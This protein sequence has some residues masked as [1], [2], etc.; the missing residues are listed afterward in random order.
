MQKSKEKDKNAFFKIAN[1]PNP[2]H[3]QPTNSQTCSESFPKFIV[4]HATDNRKLSNA[5]PF[6]ISK[7]VQGSAGS[8]KSIKKLPSR[9]LLIETATQARSI[10]LL[11][12]TNLS[13][14]SITATLHKTLNSSLGVIYY[15][16]L[17]PLPNSEIEDL[18]SQGVETVKRITSIQDG[19]TVT[20]PLFI[21]TFSKHT[22][23]ENVLI[24]YLN[25][26]IRPYIPNPLRCFRCQSYG[27]ETASCPA[28]LPAI[29]AVVRSMPA[30]HV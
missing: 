30:K 24:V 14:I 5:S 23:P 2:T 12:Y 20:F 7:A 11:Q 22:L 10:N 29:N 13:N 3:G 18:A 27:H 26:K 16:D 6:L 4:L 25:I 9:D 28:L 21:L 15:P 17:I 1:P 19:K 8:V